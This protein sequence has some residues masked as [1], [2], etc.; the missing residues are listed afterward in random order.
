MKKHLLLLSTLFLLAGSFCSCE[1][2]DVKN[3]ANVKDFYGTRVVLVN[4]S[5]MPRWLGERVNH[6]ESQD[7]WPFL[8]K[9]CQFKGKT[10]YWF[11]SYLD[12]CIWCELYDS[13]GNQ[14]E[15]VLDEFPME[16]TSSDAAWEII[17]AHPSL[18]EWSDILEGQ[19]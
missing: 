7:W 5:E 2:E 6:F 11:D 15:T 10:Y 19:Q 18:D 16:I 17:Y 12:S 1:K 14:W 8:L 13:E 3:D 9:K 4:K